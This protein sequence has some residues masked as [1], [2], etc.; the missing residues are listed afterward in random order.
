MSQS[1]YLLFVNVSPKGVPDDTWIKWW[2]S[3]HIRSLLQSGVCDKVALYKEI[4]FAMLPKPDHSQRFLA[5]YQT[6][7][8]RLQDDESFEAV[9]PEEYCDM[10]NYRVRN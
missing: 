2:K 5:V 4:G 9:S 3:Q 10:R 6:D 1:P 8:E 7:C